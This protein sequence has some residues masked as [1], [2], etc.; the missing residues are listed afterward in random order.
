MSGRRFGY[1][2]RDGKQY[3]IIGQSLYQERNKPSDLRDVYVRNNQ[4]K[5]VSLD[6]VISLEEMAKPPQLYHYDR[7]TSATISSGLA[8]GKTI[9]DGIKEM[10]RIAKDVLDDSFTT[11]LAG[12]SRDFAESSSNTMFALILALVLIYLV[13]A[14]Q[15]ES[16]VEPFI[17]MLTVPMALS[18]ALFSLWYFNVKSVYSDLLTFTL[19]PIPLILAI[20]LSILIYKKEKL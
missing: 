19:F 4:G 2:L 1:F 15:F 12:S 18:G 17:I 10:Q 16:F 3:Q 14:A 20:Y 11:T 6:N 8:T 5:L 9:G 13:L 7:Y